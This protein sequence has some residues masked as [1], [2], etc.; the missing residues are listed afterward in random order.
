M[1]TA[2]Q[3]AARKRLAAKALVAFG[4]ILI[5]AAI[6]VALAGGASVALTFLAAGLGFTTVRALQFVKEEAVR[7]AELQIAE[8][9]MRI[10]TLVEMSRARDED[11][12][13]LRKIIEATEVELEEVR[14]VRDAVMVQVQKKKGESPCATRSSD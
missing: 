14:K 1:A 10:C 9:Q 11:I 7:E 13:R 12:A 4:L 6:I 5:V 2:L 8:L 3:V